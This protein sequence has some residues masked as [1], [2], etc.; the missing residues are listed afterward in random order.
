MKEKQTEHSHQFFMGR[1]LDLAEN[2]LGK[3]SPNPL[4]GAVIVNN[5]LIIGEGY[6]K[7][8]GQ[9]H[10]EVNA[11]N[12]VRDSS[13]LH[14]ST[15]Y[16]NLE[17]CAHLGKTPPCSDLII[18]KKIP[19]VVIGTS[20]PNA[21]VAGRGISKLKKH[22]VHVEV[23]ILKD[24]CRELNRRFFTFHEKKRPY[25]ILKWAQTSD[26]FI[27]TIRKPGEIIGINWISHPLSRM[28]VHKWR[29]EE[30]GIMIG[31]NTVLT[32]NPKLTVREWNGK[33]PV[34]I[35]LD[36]NLRIQNDLHVFKNDAATLVYNERQSKKNGSVEW[37]RLSF[38]DKNLSLV[39]DDLYQRELLSIIVEGGKELLEYFITCNLWDEARVFT[40]EKKFIRGLKAPEIAGRI[41]SEELLLT[42]RLCVFRNTIS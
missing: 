29:S 9:S 41:V 21:L 26:G 5:N 7:Q 37:V 27:D 42:D 22:G 10:A 40:G 3:V 34:R 18:Q 33:N 15:L 32:D 2:G 1:C 31:T 17:P 38:N 11:I 23:D 30:Q 36:R 16:V 24:D 28:L 12:S 35:I 14:E 20:D 8:F 13:V 19:L 39:L 6:H 25:I 4:V